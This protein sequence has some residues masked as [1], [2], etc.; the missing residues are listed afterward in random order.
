MQWKSTVGQPTH[1]IVP[2]ED[3]PGLFQ[4]FLAN[5][6]L[7]NIFQFITTEVNLFIHLFEN[8]FHREYVYFFNIEFI[9]IIITNNKILFNNK[10]ISIVLVGIFYFTTQQQNVVVVVVMVVRCIFNTI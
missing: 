10:T 1:L 6:S 5:H 3:D 2:E 7:L 4:S 9:I 8:S